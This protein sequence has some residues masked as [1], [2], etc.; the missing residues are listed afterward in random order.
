MLQAQYA[1]TELEVES[2]F[3][4]GELRVDPVSGYIDGPGG[5]EEV[6]PRL[7][8]VLLALAHHPGELVSREHLIDE[9]WTDRIVSDETLTQCVYQLRQ[10]FEKAGG[11]TDYREWITTLPKRGYLL[12]GEVMPIDSIVAAN[13]PSGSTIWRSAGLLAI[14]AALIGSWIVVTPS[15]R[16]LPESISILGTGPPTVAV[17]PFADISPDQDLGYFS[18]GISEEILHQLGDYK[19]LQ[20]IARTSSF[21]FKDSDF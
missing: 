6:D 11:D 14:L 12:N 2:G 21:S 8:E 5:R 16:G 15:G 1:T 10:H 4:L 20:V 18:D 3:Q 13:Q 17:L 19:E 7:M 9:V